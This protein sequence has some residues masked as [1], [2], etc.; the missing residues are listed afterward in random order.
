MDLAEVGVVE[1]M[2][3]DRASQQLAHESKIS[4]F[5]IANRYRERGQ[6]PG[7]LDCKSGRPRRPGRADA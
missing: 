7:L 4:K 5:D 1:H 6:R 2:E 3:S